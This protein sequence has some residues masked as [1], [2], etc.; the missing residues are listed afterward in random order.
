[1]IRY[2]VLSTKKLDPLLIEQAKQANIEILEQE[3][4]SVK[5]ITSKENW[6]EVFECIKGKP[7]HVVF[8]S[9][10]AVNAVKKYLHPYV[11]FETVDWRVFCLSGR[12][13]ESVESIPELSKSIVDTASDATTLA[14]KIIGHHIRKI[15]FFCGDQRRDELPDTL[16]N[17][18]IDVLEIVVYTTVETP[19]K[20]DAHIDAILFFSPSAVNSF[21]SVNQINPQTVCFAIG[22]T[23]ANALRE[24]T[25]NEVIVSSSTSQEGI[26]KTMNNF[27]KQKDD[28]KNA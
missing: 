5:P 13:K 24:S 1:M 19:V 26:M 6:D 17:E 18:A 16:K 28:L 9:S 27:F 2:K 14:K 23:T 25:A 3:F 4:I 21:F 11:N 12:T 7:E 15:V 10:N 22:Q 20:F 8:T